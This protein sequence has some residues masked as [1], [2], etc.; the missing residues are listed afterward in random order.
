M[1]WWSAVWRLLL[2]L[3]A[4]RRLTW[5]PCWRRMLAVVWLLLRRLL[6]VRLIRVRLAWLSLRRHA[7]WGALV[8]RC[9]WLAL[10]RGVTVIWLLRLLLVRRLLGISARRWSSLWRGTVRARLTVVR[11]LRAHL[12]D[13]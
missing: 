13:G 10:L 2:L 7:S 11:L 8:W 9:W 4:V 3:L 12:W 6:G 5:L 1:R